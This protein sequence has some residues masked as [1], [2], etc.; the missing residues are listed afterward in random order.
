MTPRR[1]PSEPIVLEALAEERRMALPSEIEGRWHTDVVL[2]RDVF[3]TVERGHFATPEAARSR[4]C[5]AGSTKFLVDFGRSALSPVRPRA[6]ALAAAGTLGI[7]PPLLLSGGK[8]PGPRLDRRRRAAYR[9]ARRRRRTI[10]APPRRRCA[11]CIARA[12]A[13]TISPRNRTGCAV[14]TAGL[15]HR[16]SARCLVSSA[17]TRC[18]ASPPTRICVIC[19][20]INAVMLRP[21]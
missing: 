8:C 9:Q 5:C 10:S 2:K 17:A 1:C 19:S 3:S 12:S 21:P 15:S 13:T 7:A 16:L 6:A 11:S 20:S 18:F 14:A 4:P